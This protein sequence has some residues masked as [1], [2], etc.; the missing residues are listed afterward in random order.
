MKLWE[1]KRKGNGRE[2]VKTKSGKGKRPSNKNIAKRNVETAGP[3][4]LIGK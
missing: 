2:R 1:M 4:C 3:S